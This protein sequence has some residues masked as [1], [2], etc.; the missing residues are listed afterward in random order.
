MAQRSKVGSG[1]IAR[2]ADEG[3]LHPDPITGEPGAHPAGTGVGAVGGAVAGAVL[4]G[5]VGGPVGAAIGSAI[6]AVGGG[7]AGSNVAESLNPTEEDAYWREN[8]RKRPYADETLSYDHYRPAYRYGWESRTRMTGRRWDEVE[9][10]LERGWRE[11]RGASR[12]GWPDAKLAARDA[13]QRVDHR[14]ADEREA[15]S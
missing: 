6:G 9:R 2:T 1:N 13:W 5:A 7:A 4:G 14:L 15:R 11:N 8:F 3:D 12:L 10:D